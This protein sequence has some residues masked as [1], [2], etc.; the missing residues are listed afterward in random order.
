MGIVSSFH[1]FWVPITGL[2]CGEL[3]AQERLVLFCV[4]FT[5][6]LLAHSGE[7][8]NYII[9][10]PDPLGTLITTQIRGR[11]GAD[12][13]EGVLRPILLVPKPFCSPQ[14]VLRPIFYMWRLAIWDEL[15]TETR[16]RGSH[17]DGKIQRTLVSGTLTL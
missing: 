3:S 13:C 7:G 14:R 5:G 11:W 12:L 8:P 17:S 15:L 6:A 10:S 4:C 2:C 9:P 16:Y 1:F